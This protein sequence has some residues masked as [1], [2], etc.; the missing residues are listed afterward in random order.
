LTLS[1]L[2]EAT[3]V[4]PFWRVTDASVVT[5]GSNAEDVKA[6]THFQFILPYAVIQTGTLVHIMALHCTDNAGL[7]VAD[8]TLAF[9]AVSADGERWD[10]LQISSGSSAYTLAI[11][12]LMEFSN[13]STR[14][15]Y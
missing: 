8:N 14:K 1:D 11:D 4:S 6:K 13:T 12:W 15:E 3:P 9:Y 7:D 2:R 5:S 10:D